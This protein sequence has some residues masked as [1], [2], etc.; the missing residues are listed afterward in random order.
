MNDDELYAAYRFH[1]GELLMLT[2]EISAEIDRIRVPSSRFIPGSSSPVM[3]LLVT[4]RFYAMG[5]LQS[6]IGEIFGVDQSTTSRTIDRVTAAMVMQM[7][8]WARLPSQAEADM[9][10]VKFHAK[11]GF[12]VAAWMEHIHIRAPTQNEH[13]YVN[14]KNYHSL[15]VQVTTKLFWCIDRLN[16]LVIGFDFLNIISVQ[17]TIHSILILDK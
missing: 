11:A 17:S 3:Q 5:T 12:P 2:D 16:G 6:V 10:K 8:R 1:C 9:Q 7:S 15:S 4:L 14:R 13:E